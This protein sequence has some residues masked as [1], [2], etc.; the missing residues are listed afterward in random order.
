MSSSAYSQVSL[1][2]LLNKSRGKQSLIAS[3]LLTRRKLLYPEQRPLSGHFSLAAHSILWEND[4]K[5]NRSPTGY[6]YCRGIPVLTFSLE[7][8]SLLCAHFLPCIDLFGT[9]ALKMHRFNRS[10]WQNTKVFF[11]KQ[12]VLKKLQMGAECE[13]HQIPHHLKPKPCLLT[14]RGQ[15]R[16]CLKPTH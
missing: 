3:Q 11:S 8:V 6:P 16:S 15:G 12:A 5:H 13:V 9:L 1:W 7:L 4:S 10:D 2:F 14:L